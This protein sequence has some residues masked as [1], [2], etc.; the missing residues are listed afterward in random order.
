MV[1]PKELLSA[2]ESSFFGP[3]P[4]APAQRVELIHALRKSRSSFQSLLSYQ[5]SPFL[6]ARLMVSTW[7]ASGC[8]TDKKFAEDFLV[9]EFNRNVLWEV[10]PWHGGL[11]L[12][13][14]FLALL[15]WLV[16][17]WRV[18]IGEV[19][20]SPR[21][22]QWWFTSFMFV[23][24]T[25]ECEVGKSENFPERIDGKTNLVLTGNWLFLNL[26]AALIW[27]IQNFDGQRSCCSR[28]CDISLFLDPSIC[29]H[30]HY[31]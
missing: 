8:Q 19:L 10:A 14:V 30:C 29:I 26:Y 6:F 22:L 9:I 27:D 7:P 2:I 25:S 17:V 5:V 31:Y 12:G 13:I 24:R 4:P 15:S 23:E 11:F 3:S 18:Q 20:I 28:F 16:D 1:S 21:E